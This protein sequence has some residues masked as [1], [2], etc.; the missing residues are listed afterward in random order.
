MNII[1]EWSFH[2]LFIAEYMNYLHIKI[3]VF[4]DVALCRSCVNPRFGGTNRLHLQGTKIRERRTSV[5]RWLQTEPLAQFFARG[6]LY[7][8]DGG[9]SFLRN[10]G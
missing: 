4:W 8:E 9:D 2:K 6:F 5:A 3:V 10:V 7:P 1:Q